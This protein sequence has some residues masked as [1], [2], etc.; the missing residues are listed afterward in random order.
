[1]K[2]P[3]IKDLGDPK[4]M[5]FDVKPMVYGGFQ[6]LVD[7][8]SIGERHKEL[9]MS[10]PKACSYGYKAQALPDRLSHTRRRP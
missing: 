10:H 6:V 2:D 5:P 9:Q 8:R 4:N 1:M 7:A 3:R